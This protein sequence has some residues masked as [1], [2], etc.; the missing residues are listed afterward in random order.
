MS[1]MDESSFPSFLLKANRSM[2]ISTTVIPR[3]RVA[4]PYLFF[5]EKRSGWPRKTTEPRASMHYLGIRM[6]CYCRIP[7]GSS[8]NRDDMYMDKLL[9]RDL[10][11]SEVSCMVMTRNYHDR[12]FWQCMY[13]GEKVREENS[14]VRLLA[15]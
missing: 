5:L 8:H 15:D 14:T 2:K 3:D 9:D 10:W 6:P 1:I 7:S 13:S 11:I 12:Y 4:W